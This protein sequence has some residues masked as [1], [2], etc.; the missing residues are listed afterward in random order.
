MSRV[1]QGSTRLR[2]G[3]AP[4]R[5]ACVGL[6]MVAWGGSDD[7]TGGPPPRRGPGG[8]ERSCSSH[9]DSAPAAPSPVKQRRCARASTG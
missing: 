6:G 4:R 1:E 2:V 7:R 3:L 8:A 9:D 5:L